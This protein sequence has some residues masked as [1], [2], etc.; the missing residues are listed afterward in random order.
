MSDRRAMS[1]GGPRPR[2]RWLRAVARAALIAFPFLLLLPSILGGASGGLSARVENY[3]YDLRVRLSL[4]GGL[5]LRIVLV[6]ID[7][8]RLAPEERWPWSRASPHR[9]RR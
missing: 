3:L 1:D 5:D 4:P 7:E 2:T 9:C 6:A 8:P